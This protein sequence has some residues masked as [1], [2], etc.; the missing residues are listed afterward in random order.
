MGIPN[1]YNSSITSNPLMDDKQLGSIGTMF[2]KRDTAMPY[3][4][5]PGASSMLSGKAMSVIGGGLNNQF[6]AAN[7]MGGINFDR[8]YATKNTQN[9]YR[10]EQARAN[11][12]L[13]GANYLSNEDALQQQ[14]AGNQ[15]QLQQ[16]LMQMLIP[17]MG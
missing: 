12:G 10:T 6:G 16:A 3:G 9:L 7:Q 11:S 17:Y 13:R 1:L 5:V 4:Q 2:G 15:M 14:G 8:D